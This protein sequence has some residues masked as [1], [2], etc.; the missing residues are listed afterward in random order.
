MSAA[1]AWRDP[2]PGQSLRQRDA[3]THPER[4]LWRAVQGGGARGDGLDR[5]HTDKLYTIAAA[6]RSAVGMAPNVASGVGASRAV[7]VSDAT[8]R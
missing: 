7:S 5:L 8:G 1:A 2:E 6:G 3:C 4:D